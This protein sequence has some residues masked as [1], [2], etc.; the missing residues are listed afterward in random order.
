M[1]RRTAK[2]L[3]RKPPR[4]KKRNKLSDI[5]KKAG[6]SLPFLFHRTAAR[7]GCSGLLLVARLALTDL[8]AHDL[9]VELPALG[10]DLLQ[11][12]PG[13]RAGLRVKDDLLAKEHQG[14]NRAN[15]E[16]ARKFLL[17]LG[18]YLSIN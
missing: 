5:S 8:L 6:D 18:V 12:G 9:H 2:R 15:V 17:F 11:R 10:D 13:Q 14:R 3:P 1:A 4:K 16:P 7:H